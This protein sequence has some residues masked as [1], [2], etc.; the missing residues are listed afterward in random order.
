MVVTRAANPGTCGWHRSRDGLGVM[1][2]RPAL[3]AL[4]ALLALAPM[5][6]CLANAAGPGMA[7][8]DDGTG[9][10]DDDDGVGPDRDD[11]RPDPGLCVGDGGNG[12][13]C[14][15]TGDCDDPL[16]CLGG[17]CVGPNDP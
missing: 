12:G 5:T 2:L 10:D 8:D 9:D 6:G 4:L 7:G 1:S 13:V 3:L 17:R 16:I 14:E 15:V 11:P